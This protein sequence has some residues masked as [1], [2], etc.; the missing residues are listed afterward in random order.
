MMIWRWSPDCD[1]IIEVVAENLEIKKALLA[2]VEQHRRPGSI[3]TSNTS[4]TADPRDCGG[5]SDEA[6]PHFFG[7]HF[8][9]PPRYMRLLEIIPTAETSPIR[10]CGGDRALCDAAAGQGGG[11]VA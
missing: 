6:R 2:K 10:G 8:F 1:W 4:G 11:A 9:N 7:T 3:L 5:L